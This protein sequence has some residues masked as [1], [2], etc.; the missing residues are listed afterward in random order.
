MGWKGLENTRGDGPSSGDGGHESPPRLA[1]H[2]QCMGVLCTWAAFVGY[3][4]SKTFLATFKRK[5]IIK[6]YFLATVRMPS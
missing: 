1:M 6:I 5:L 2:E 3:F 4:T